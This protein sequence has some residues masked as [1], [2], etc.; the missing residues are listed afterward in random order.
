MSELVAKLH[1]YWLVLQDHGS[2][3]AALGLRVY[4]ASVLVQP[5]YIKLNGSGR[6]FERLGVPF[7]D[8]T[9]F[10]VG[11][12]EFFGAIFLLI[13][14]CT[15][16]LT[17]PLMCIMLVAGL[18]VHAEY[19]WLITADGQS[20]WKNERVEKGQRNKIEITRIVREHGDY[21]ELTDSGSITILNNGMQLAITYFLM[22]LALLF[23]GGGKYT[24]VDHYIAGVFRRRTSGLQLET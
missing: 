15:R 7:P 16:L 10:V 12:F 8:F 5:G 11:C 23:L 1:G 20:W 17:V 18:L 21:R 6:F 3:V 4:L 22:L 14:L 9:N 13:G 24:S 19:G 2:G